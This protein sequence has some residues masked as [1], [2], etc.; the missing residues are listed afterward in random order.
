VVGLEMPSFIIG[1]YLSIMIIVNLLKKWADLKSSRP[2][3]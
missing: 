2:Q 1:N 3:K